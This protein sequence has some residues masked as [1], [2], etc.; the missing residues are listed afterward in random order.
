MSRNLT[1]QVAIGLLLAALLVSIII[2]IVQFDHIERTVLETRTMIER[3]ETLLGGLQR[4][5]DKQGAVVVTAPA[6]V[7]APATPPTLNELLTVDPTP[8]S[9]AGAKEGGE[10]HLASTTDFKGFNLLVEGSADVQELHLT[11]VGNRI[12]RRHY[13][14][15]EAWHGELATSVT[16]SDDDLVY[17]VKLR[18]GVKWHRPAVDLSNPRMKW[19]DVDR[20]VV[21][22]DFV[23][24]LEMIRDEKVSGA[25]P[26]RSF[27]EFLDRVEAIND[28]EFKVYWKKRVY[29]S[30]STT[31][32]LYP[33]PRW[34][35]GADEDG[36]LYPKETVG[37]KLD[38]HW[39]NDRAIGTGPFRFVESKPGEFV[40]LTRNEDYFATRPP[41]KGITYQIIRDPGAQLLR[42]KNGE[43][44]L[45]TLSA[46]QYRK[47]IQEAAA[48]S[49]FKTGRF[50]HDVIPRLAYRYLGWNARNPLFEDKRVRRAMTHAFDREKIVKDV[51]VGL[52]RVITGGF[53]VDA[54]WYDKSIAP[55]PFDLAEAARLLDEAG[56]R[57]SDGDGVRDRL[58][59]GRKLDFEFTLLI[60][61]NFP[62]IKSAADIFKED[63]IKVGV[64]LTVSP[65]DWPAM[66]KKMEDKEFEAY[67]G[68]W[69]LLWEEDPNQLWH[70]S[71]AD[72]PKGSNFVNFRNAEADRI[73][74]EAQVTFDFEGR[75]RLL[76]RFHAIV[77]EEQPYTF[78]FAPDTV[79]TYHA[80]LKNVTYQKPRP[81]ILYHLM[82]KDQ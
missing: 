42:F 60:Y 74:E 63:L 3:Q 47:E 59:E 4:T 51:F 58:V 55:F 17:H 7:D 15:P 79:V 37:L 16:H 46:T 34:L 30:R 80:S 57:D 81:Q 68:G 76:N 14:D 48:D 31:L 71:Q 38:T 50:K 41:L 49:P 27:F 22:D 40:R 67:T 18:P 8:L 26:Q 82:W 9:P 28:R 77:H 10:L 53:Y 24:A 44:D 21:A 65:V 11:L 13:G 19:L 78:F 2:N 33:A 72:K 56:W 61:N 29:T 62:E 43:L 20:E 23:F 54:P 52:G 75:K 12:A 36:N 32:G 45:M 1:A 39:Y 70:S 5:L 6:A 66:Q 35:Y 69:G 25:A 64:K 73:I